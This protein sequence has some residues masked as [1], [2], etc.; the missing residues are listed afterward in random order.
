MRILC[1][2]CSH[3]IEVGQTGTPT[4]I[5]DD[6]PGSTIPQGPRAA[7]RRAC[8]HERLG[9]LTLMD[10]VGAGSFGEVWKAHDTELNRLVAVKIP[11]AGYLSDGKDHDRFLSEARSAAVLRHPGIVP[12]HEVGHDQG[13]SY[14]VCDFIEGLTL[15]DLLKARRLTFTETAE[16][17]AQVAEALDYAHSMGVVHRDVKP[18]NIILECPGA[19]PAAPPGRPMLM[20]FGLALRSDSEITLTLEGQVLGTPA[21]MSPELAA[22][23]GHQVDGRSDVYSV[24]VVLY[25]LLAG[26][27]P[28]RGNSRMLRD[29]I[30]YREPLPPRQ[31]NDQVPN[32]LQ[33]ITLKC[34]AKEASRR[35]QTAGELAADLRRWLAGE[36]IHARPVGRAERLW[37]WCRRNPLPA[38]L[39]ATVASLLVVAAVGASV[40]AIWLGRAARD[41]DEARKKEEAARR[42]EE[43]TLADT[44]VS[45]GV[46]ALQRDDPARAVLWFAHAARLSGDDPERE[47]ANR[48]RVRAAARQAPV[49]VQVFSHPGQELTRLAFHL[50]GRHLLTV[51]RRQQCLV[52]DLGREQPL[53]W[54]S[55]EKPV[56]AAVWAP[57]GAWLALGTP[58]GAVEIRGFPG[59]E[60]Q[61]RLQIR[62][63]V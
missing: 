24:G 54:A 62:G 8:P 63:P 5:P 56:S 13:L 52:W 1:P 18:S 43:L 32:D 46:A 16:L 27:L 33:T 20:D 49:P 40:A 21:Y 22:G 50:G 38:V 48:I 61:H 44:Y 4:D 55:G 15:T 39:A 14:L 11:H 23:H 7:R 10:R 25:Q 37:R 28:F 9:K 45:Q 42:A 3:L 36:P 2:H 17:I 47:R 29:Q 53:G 35:Y 30:L 34:L 6:T 51:S 60:Q 58:E 31:L 59:G 41:A 57:D 12:V 19:D 26:E